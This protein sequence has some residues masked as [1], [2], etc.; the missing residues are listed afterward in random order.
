MEN[1][2]ITVGMRVKASALGAGRVLEIDGGWAR[3]SWNS[4]AISWIAFHELT[5]I[6]L[7]RKRS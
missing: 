3:V 7:R 2:E 4:G 5:P 6:Y 1:A